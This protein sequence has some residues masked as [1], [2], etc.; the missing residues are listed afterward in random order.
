MD[1]LRFACYAMVVVIVVLIIGILV[2]GRDKRERLQPE[3]PI[4]KKTE[5]EIDLRDF[6]LDPS[7]E[8]GTEN[9]RAS[10]IL[11]EDGE[12]A[13][14]HHIS[15]E[16]VGISPHRSRSGQHDMKPPGVSRV[17]Q[18]NSEIQHSVFEN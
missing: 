1:S 13:W 12:G 4:G 6:G 10:S 9:L 17:H 11:D 8:K 7:P 2:T 14:A 15:L 16:A 3:K 5:P 18:G